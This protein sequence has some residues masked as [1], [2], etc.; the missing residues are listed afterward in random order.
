M[1]Q[2]LP[3]GTDPSMYS[4]KPLDATSNEINSRPR[5]SLGGRSLMAFY[6]NLLINN[7]RHSTR[8]A[9]HF[10]GVVARCCPPTKCRHFFIDWGRPFP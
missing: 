2:N 5:K 8:A 6:R 7:P 9:R 4:Q 10:S 1:F 3:K